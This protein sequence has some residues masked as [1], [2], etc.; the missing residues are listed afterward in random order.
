VSDVPDA[1]VV[2]T[3]KQAIDAGWVGGAAAARPILARLTT[4]ELAGLAVITED[5]DYLIK[6]MT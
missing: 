1:H 4:D 6:E 3:L 2:E 5:L